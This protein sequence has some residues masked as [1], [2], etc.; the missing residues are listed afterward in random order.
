MT[1]TSCEAERNEL[2]L[3][4][5]MTPRQRLARFFELMDVVEGIQKADPP[6][7]CEM[8]GSV[9]PSLPSTCSKISKPLG[10]SLNPGMH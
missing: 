2:D 4:R 9:Q 7:T 6:S 3:F 5:K 1:D 10:V 8:Y